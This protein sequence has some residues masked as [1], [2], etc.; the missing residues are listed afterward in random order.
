[1]NELRVDI[2]GSNR[3]FVIATDDT[4]R[5]ARDLNRS[6][7]GSTP[8]TFKGAQ[9]MR[10]QYG[11]MFDDLK[12]P[13][14]MGGLL[15]QFAGGFGQAGQAV[16][17]L[18]TGPIGVLTVALTAVYEAGKMAWATMK[19]SFQL[20]RDAR[21]LGMSTTGLQRLDQADIAQGFEPGEARGRLGKFANTV[22]KAEEGD[23]AAREVFKD[24]GV[25]ISGKTMEQILNQVAE[26]FDRI[27]DPAKRAHEAVVLFGRGGQE[28]IPILQ[29]LKS[30]GGIPGGLFS[31]ES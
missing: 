17:Q 16:L 24:M 19:E 9:M 14:G 28:M 18:A 31:N 13:Q 10:D 4:K 1:M 3:G 2:G 12:G 11:K 20:G 21:T 30:C 15:Q 5:L 27:Q 7:S 22:G 23:K 26:A 8:D 25:E 6:L 29:Q